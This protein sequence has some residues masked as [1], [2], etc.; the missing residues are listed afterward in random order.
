MIIF[1]SSYL[2][3]FIIQTFVREYDPFGSKEGIQIMVVQRRYRFLGFIPCWAS[4]KKTKA[5]SVGTG[6]PIPVLLWTE[7]MVSHAD[8]MLSLVRNAWI[9]RTIPMI[10][11]LALL[12]FFISLFIEPDIPNQH[13]QSDLISNPEAGDLILA[14]VTP[15]YYANKNTSPCFRLFRI[16]GING[17][18]LIVVRSLHSEN[19]MQK[20]Y[21]INN[22]KLIA[23]FDTVP[24]AFQENEEVYSSAIYRE[25]GKRF[26]RIKQNPETLSEEE[27][28]IQDSINKHTDI[29]E[30]LYIKRT[31]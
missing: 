7:S 23:L 9:A 30:P 15:S 8:N 31:Y 1:F 6:K 21:I 22:D 3:V 25:G 13:N 20:V 12:L 24:E 5:Y 28:N 4:P 19:T 2:K 11:L 17:D 16:K 29:I 27:K 14:T 10:G 26:K 18:S